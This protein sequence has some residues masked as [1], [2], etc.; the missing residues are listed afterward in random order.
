MEVGGRLHYKIRRFSPLPSSALQQQHRE[1]GEHFFL[2]P[3]PCIS[4][5]TSCQQS[6]CRPAGNVIV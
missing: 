3:A 5:T 1:L 2:L 4:P 6:H